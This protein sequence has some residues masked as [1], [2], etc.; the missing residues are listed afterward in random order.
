MQR[1]LILRDWEVNIPL[2]RRRHGVARE[3]LQ[4]GCGLDI[5]CDDHSVLAK[6]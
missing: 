1:S 6:V 4:S 5:R 2:A 3:G